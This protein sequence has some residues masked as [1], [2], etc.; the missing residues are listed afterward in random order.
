M[1]RECHVRFCERLRGQFLRPTHHFGMKAH[2]GVD[3]RTGRVHSVLATAANEADVTQVDRLLHGKEKAVFADAGY[4]GADKRVPAKRGRR[5]WIAAKRCTVKGHHRRDAV[6]PDRGA[7]ACQNLDSCQGGTSSFPRR[8]AP[9]RTGQGALSL[10][11]DECGARDDSVCAGQPMDGAQATAGHDRMGA[12]RKTAS[13]R[14]NTVIRGHG[15]IHR[16]SSGGE[17]SYSNAY[18]LQARVNQTILSKIR[19]V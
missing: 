16:F 3:E 13:P 5:W 8:E 18:R 12:A 1:T 19:C 14:S 6:R 17:F 4:I 9:V 15:C 2:S 7:G 10:A 11:G